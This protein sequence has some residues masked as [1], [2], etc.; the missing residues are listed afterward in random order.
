MNK[1]IDIKRIRVIYGIAISL[2]MLLISIWFILSPDIFIRNQWMKA[3]HIQTFGVI[4]SVY[5]TFLLYSFIQIYSRRVGII[6]S[7]EYL[8]D[9]TR[10]E[11]LGKI[12]WSEITSIQKFKK[13]SIEIIF[14]EPI[15][16]NKK[17]SM[18]KKILLYMNNYNPNLRIFISSA[19]IDCSTEELFKYTNDA[20]EKSDTS[21][22]LN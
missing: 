1:E 4:A 6:I 3:A 10:Y 7:S 22:K 2:T 14:K 5:F 18:F 9:L 15:L 12:K 20:L 11:S 16:K 19:L 8:M 13:S 17:L 21:R